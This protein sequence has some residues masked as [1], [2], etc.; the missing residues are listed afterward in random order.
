MLFNP[1]SEH[2]VLSLYC[3]IY[4]LIT[5]LTFLAFT[6]YNKIVIKHYLLTVLKWYPCTDLSAIIAYT[7]GRGSMPKRF[8]RLTSQEEL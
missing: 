2:Y 8:N 5:T 1:L 7:R 3:S 4:F 6:V